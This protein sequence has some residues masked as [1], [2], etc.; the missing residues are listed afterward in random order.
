[1]I[2]RL[3][4]V[5]FAFFAAFGGNAYAAD[6]PRD[7]GPNGNHSI[8][9]PAPKT[10]SLRWS[11]KLSDL[12]SGIYPM[13]PLLV[14]GDK[15][16]LGGAGTN[17]VIALDKTTGE[18][19]WRFVPD[20]RN[21]GHFGAYPN[22]NHPEISKGVYY[23]TSTNGFLYALDA[24]T[25]RKIWSFQVT[26]TEY[27]K[28]ITRLAICDGKVFFDVL[29][30]IPAK[31]QSNIYA[32][33]AGTGREVW[34]K[35]AGAPDYPGDGIWPD[36]PASPNQADLAALGRSTRRFEAR[37][38]LACS[39]GRVQSFGEDGVLRLLD[40][41][42]GTVRGKYSIAHASMDLGF[43]VDGVAG[44]TDSVTGDLL[45]GS[46]NNRLVRLDQEAIE[47]ICGGE[48]CPTE[49]EEQMKVDLGWRHPYGDCSGRS[50]CGIVSVG[51]QDLLPTYRGSRADGVIGGSVFAGGLALATWENGKRVA[52]VPN[53]DGY[54]YAMDWDD[55]INDQ[56]EP[57]VFKA[58]F[59]GL[60]P[61][62]RDAAASRRRDGIN[63]Y[64]SDDAS[65]CLVASN[66][67][68]GPWEHHASNVSSPTVA[69]GVVYVPVS[70]AH[71]M[72]GFDWKTGK[73]VWDFEVSW[74]AKSQY[75]PFGDTKPSPFIDIDLLVQ[76]TPA[77]DGRNLYFTANNGVVY[78]I[79]TQEEI[80]KPR[81]NLAILGSGIV[82]FIPKWT[83]ALGAFDYVWTPEA[84]WYNPG[85]TSPDSITADQAPPGFT[86][87]TTPFGYKGATKG[88]ALPVITLLVGFVLAGLAIQ[89]RFAQSGLVPVD[90]WG[91][92]RSTTVW[93]KRERRLVAA[94]LAIV[95]ISLA[96]VSSF[97]RSP[98]T[99]F[100]NFSELPLNPASGR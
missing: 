37:P 27:N 74:D 10:H 63:L 51:R 38:G 95:L 29:G 6:W 83:Q 46:L 19:R 80:A 47:T 17:S 45:R 91:A 89:T 72:V 24:N 43:A 33:D 22:A 26:D 93:L 57:S 34:R 90:P 88:T 98:S 94:A 69:G 96:V 36:F 62:D 84:D 70:M 100:E 1:M 44:I 97:D 92:I 85:Y 73:R 58:A 16:I 76:T 40:T 25:G 81:R 77:H 65:H 41:S 82:P 3:T 21:S 32:V 35:Y 2:P 79:S 55:P 67:K 99:S 59:D 54:L 71:K 86:E 9:A 31:G 8:D 18:V 20:A 5:A 52:Y 75:P 42:D 7:T 15:V 50:D 87:A 53:H 56:G 61:A 39:R 49:E 66:C 28:A 30:G 4:F 11:T 68:N 14:Y 78:A 48:V 60:L 12:P 64:T 23:T 13:S